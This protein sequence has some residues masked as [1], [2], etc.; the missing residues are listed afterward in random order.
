[1]ASLWGAD[2][3]EE[4]EEGEDATAV[5]D[6][7][8]QGCLKL[9]NERATTEGTEPSRFTREQIEQTSFAALQAGGSQLR[10]T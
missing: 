2:E 5:E 7:N 1:M 4:G 10:R 3:D 8:G 6:G 9:W